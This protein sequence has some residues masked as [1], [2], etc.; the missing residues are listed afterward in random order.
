[1]KGIVIFSIIWASM[2]SALADYPTVQEAN[3]RLFTNAIIIWRAPTDDLPKNFWIY[4]RTLPRIFSQAVNR[5]MVQ[6][7]AVGP[8][9]K[10]PCLAQARMKRLDGV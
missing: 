9:R 6:N 5:G 8:A 2:F 1:M 10:M 3:S 7:V 4:Q